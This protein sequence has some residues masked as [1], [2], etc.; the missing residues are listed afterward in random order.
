MSAAIEIAALS[1]RYETRDGPVLALDDVS[2]AIQP[3]EFVSVLGPSGCGKTTL[4]K[5]IAGLEAAR[6]SWMPITRVPKLI[7]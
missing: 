5:V 4:L 1:K 2:F 6:N 3:S 7:H